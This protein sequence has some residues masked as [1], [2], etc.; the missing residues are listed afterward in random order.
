MMSESIV[1]SPNPTIADV[2]EAAG[3]S[4][5]T[6]SRAL[7]NRPDVA[8]HTRE[9]VERIAAEIGYHG[10]YGNRHRSRRATRYITLLAHGVDNEY[11]GTICRGVMDQLDP[12]IYQL[13]LHLTDA[14]VTREAD[15]VRIARRTGSE[16]LLIVTPRLRDRDF[17]DLV[18]D[19]IPYVL[20]D[21]HSDTPSVPCLR[22]TNWQGAREAT[23]H[24]IALGHRRIGYIA[25]RR[26]D[27]IAETREHGYRSALAEAHIPFAPELLADGDYSWTAGF[28]AA[29]QL[30]SLDNPPTAVF[31]SSDLMAFGAI[32][33]IYASGLRV[34]EDV[35]IVGFDDLP[36]AATIHPP[37]TT[38][39]QPLYDMGRMA[40][41]MIVSL[42][43]GQDVVSRQIELPTRLIVR[44]SCR[45]VSPG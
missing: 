43:N 27:R 7:N 39:R 42:V 14:E 32:A 11:I 41:Q 10:R 24:L 13:V 20:I 23:N 33:A 29:Q 30:L 19:R 28:R 6:V 34:P 31:A 21:F 15:Y 38:M 3:V 44:R 5:A 4:T 26:N 8:P 37:L 16:G 22:S 9:R 17:P 18:G 40:A 25:G 2:A 45:T 36:M 12:N 35:S 1:P